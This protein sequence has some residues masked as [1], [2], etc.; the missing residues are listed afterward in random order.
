M[1][2]YKAICI[3]PASARLLPHKGYALKHKGS[4]YIVGEVRPLKD[5]RHMIFGRKTVLYHTD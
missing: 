5:G 1:N 3:I 4:C 2:D